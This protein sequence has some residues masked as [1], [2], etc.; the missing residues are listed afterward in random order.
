MQKQA[1]IKYAD[2][3]V[4]HSQKSSNRIKPDPGM[5]NGSIRAAVK[6]N[7]YQ[8]VSKVVHLHKTCVYTHLEPCRSKAGVI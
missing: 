6:K 1:A 2:G 4:V 3:K 5:M 7:N 8:L